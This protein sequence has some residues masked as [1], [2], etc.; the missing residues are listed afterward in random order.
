MMQMA[1][2][3]PMNIHRRSNFGMYGYPPIG[4]PAASWA[5][6]HHALNYH[7]S[8]NVH[9]NMPGASPYPH[10][11][12]SRRNRGQRRANGND[13]IVSLEPKAISSSLSS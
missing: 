12:A 8:Q 1:S 7:P 6:T 5:P 10:F 2:H 11:D 4:Y 13:E 3:Y 9:M